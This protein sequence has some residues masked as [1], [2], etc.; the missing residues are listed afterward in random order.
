MGFGVVPLVAAMC[1]AG[2]LGGLIMP[3]RD[4]LAKMRP[5]GYACGNNHHH[6]RQHTG[7]HVLQWPSDGEDRNR[8]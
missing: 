8:N 1:C 5:Y 6:S 3:S 7:R 2:L 4:M